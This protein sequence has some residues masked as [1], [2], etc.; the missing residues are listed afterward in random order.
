MCC[1]E[2]CAGW[3]KGSTAHTGRWIAYIKPQCGEING[4]QGLRVLKII[5]PKQSGTF[6]TLG[7]ITGVSKGH[8]SKVTVPPGPSVTP[9][10]PRPSCPLLSHSGQEVICGKTESGLPSPGGKLRR[11]YWLMNLCLVSP[12]WSKVFSLPSFLQGCTDLQKRWSRKG[13]GLAIITFAPRW[14]S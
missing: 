12:T 10:V 11:N 5:G 6:C 2:S 14:A 13:P 1:E 7:E 8:R 4:G 9:P 3:G